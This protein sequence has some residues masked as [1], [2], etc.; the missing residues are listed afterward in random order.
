MPLAYAIDVDITNV[1]QENDRSTSNNVNSL[2]IVKFPPVARIDTSRLFA[3]ESTAWCSTHSTGVVL[4]QYRH[5]DQKFIAHMAGGSAGLNANVKEFQIQK[6]SNSSL[7]EA[8]SNVVDGMVCALP[9]VMGN[10]RHGKKKTLVRILHDSGSQISLLRAG[11]V[12]SQGGQ[13]QDFE[14]T[15][16]GG[17]TITSKIRVLEATLEC[18][19][20]SFSRDVHLAEM[21]KPC[22]NAP[23]VTNAQIRQYTYLS[24]VRVVE[25]PDKTIDVLCNSAVLLP[26]EEIK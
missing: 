3:H 26:P 24:K 21:K 18:L 17:D 1:S 10:L 11:I 7:T 2:P 25:P 4:E 22:E 8:G 6:Y 20:G 16:V 9:T 5:N 12:K 14:L 13:V 19:D 15:A 23:I